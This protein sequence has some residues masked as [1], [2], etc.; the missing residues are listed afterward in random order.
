MA[1]GKPELSGS[2][3]VS[4]VAKRLGVSDDT[5]RPLIEDG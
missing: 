2:V 5:V 4:I 3:P 1:E